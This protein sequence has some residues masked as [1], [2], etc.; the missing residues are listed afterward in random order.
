[1]HINKLSI[2]TNSVKALALLFFFLM[3]STVSS[4]YARPVPRKQQDK[5]GIGIQ[6]LHCENQYNPLGIDALHPRLGWI[7]KSSAGER[8]QYRLTPTYQE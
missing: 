2:S 3:I 7:L 1:M 6:S 5:P 8:G 4:L